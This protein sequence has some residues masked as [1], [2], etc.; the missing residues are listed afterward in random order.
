MQIKVLEYNQ[1]MFKMQ[2]TIFLFHEKRMN[3]CDSIIDYKCTLL[4]L[5]LH[6]YSVQSKALAKYC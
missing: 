5:T 1:L 2:M 6:D 3:L 4:S